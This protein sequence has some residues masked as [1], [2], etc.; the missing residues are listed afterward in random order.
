MFQYEYRAAGCS[1]RS[2]ILML[3]RWIKIHKEQGPD[4]AFFLKKLLD[5]PWRMQSITY[6]IDCIMCDANKSTLIFMIKSHRFATES[7]SVLVREVEKCSCNSYFSFTSCLYLYS[8]HTFLQLTDAYYRH[9][10]PIF[11]GWDE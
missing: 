10:T 11:A 9:N 5:K 7:N 4:R 8:F 3:M 1:E 6:F 2:G